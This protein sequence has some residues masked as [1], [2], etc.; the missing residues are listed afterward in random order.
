M[1]NIVEI[2]HHFKIPT[3]EISANSIIPIPGRADAA[4]EFTATL[5]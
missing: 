2:S 5:F 4:Y 3:R 1:D